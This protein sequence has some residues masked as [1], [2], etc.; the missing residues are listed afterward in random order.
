M[1]TGRFAKL[2]EDH[3]KENQDIA[4]DVKNTIIQKDKKV[5]SLVLHIV[6]FTMY[7]GFLFG[8]RRIV[9]VNMLQSIVYVIKC[10][11]VWLQMWLKIFLQTL[12]IFVA[13]LL[14]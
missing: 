9:I 13:F 11:G 12:S 4:T 6:K 7:C 1:L 3:F 8:A 5:N 10:K 14:Y 2:V